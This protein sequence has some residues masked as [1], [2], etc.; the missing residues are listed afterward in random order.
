MSLQKIVGNGMEYVG[1]I[2]TMTALMNDV[3]GCAYRLNENVSAFESCFQT[4]AAIML[5]SIPIY[6][7]GK[8]IYYK[9]IV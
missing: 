2:G 9:E 8:L 7:A 5:V 4:N 3:V 1:L 6:L